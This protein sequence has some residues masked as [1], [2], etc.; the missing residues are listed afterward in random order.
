MNNLPRRESEEGGVGKLVEKAK[1][2]IM[3]AELTLTR[4]KSGAAK[5]FSKE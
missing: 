4:R 3:C 5:A 1:G 2:I